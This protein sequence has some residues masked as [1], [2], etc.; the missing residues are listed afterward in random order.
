MKR[1][2]SEG[3]PL[4]T[5]KNM[6]SKINIRPD[7]QRN[8]VWGKANKEA[9]IDTIIQDEYSPEVIFAIP[10]EDSSYEREVLDG[11]QRLTT[12]FQFFANEIKTPDETLVEINGET[13]DVSKKYYSEL[14]QVIKDRVD[15]YQL[16]IVLLDGTRR[17]YE[18][19][20]KKLQN[21]LTLNKAE[22]RHAISGSIQ[23]VVK[24]LIQ[25]P[26]FVEVC[27]VNTGR[28]NARKQY[29]EVVEQL[30]VLELFGI[31]NIKDT[32]I[33]A[34]YDAYNEIGLPEEKMSRLEKIFDYMYKAFGETVKYKRSYFKKTNI[35]GL[36]LVLSDYINED[37]KF[38]NALKFGEWF[39]NFEESRKDKNNP[40]FSEYNNFLASGTGNREF[41]LG[42]K[43][44][45]MDSWLSWLTSGDS[46]EGFFEK[47]R[48]HSR[49]FSHELDRKH[50][51]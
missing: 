24:K 37:Q 7:Y 43:E 26:F 17:E 33:R 10:R 14:P 5:L 6:E 48:P 41:L 20:F 27:E 16:N 31:T 39:V 42:R 32:N 30:M 23:K 3:K 35:H 8:F 45:L 47:Y 49:G 12:I 29:N 2:P 1:Y 46:I 19:M 40:M 22:R 11:Q 44:I 25:H 13:F 50:I 28:A 34:M 18:K 9:Y 51:C 21:G 4:L 38:E 15:S 36:Y